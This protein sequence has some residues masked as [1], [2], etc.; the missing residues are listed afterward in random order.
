MFNS[1]EPEGHSS[2]KELVGWRAGSQ[3]SRDG[4]GPQKEND[5]MAAEPELNPSNE[6]LER[7]VVHRNIFMVMF[8]LKLS[9]V[10]I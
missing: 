6:N 8:Q 3:R 5:H 4:V 2:E 10:L 9:P 1:I 7:P